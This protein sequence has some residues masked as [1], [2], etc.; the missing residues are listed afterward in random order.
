MHPGTSNLFFCCKTWNVLIPSPHVATTSISLKFSRY[1][2]ITSIACWSRFNLLN[3]DQHGKD[4]IQYYIHH[5][6]NGLLCA[7]TTNG[8]FCQLGHLKQ[9]QVQKNSVIKFYTA[10]HRAYLSGTDYRQTHQYTTFKR[11]EWH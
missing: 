7:G 5:C 3:L 10:K 1:F 11:C 4:C 2:A 6:G 8:K 9:Y